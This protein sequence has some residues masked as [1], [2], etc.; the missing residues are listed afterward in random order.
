[1]T[2]KEKLFSAYESVKDKVICVT[3]YIRLSSGEIEVLSNCN[4]EN[5]MA[6]IDQVYDD[7]LAHSNDVRVHIED[8]SFECIDDLMD[9]GNALVN[10]K[11]GH[12]VARKGWSGKDMFLCL[13]DNID[14]DTNADLSC[15]KDLSGDLVYQSVVM[16]TVD[17]KFVVGWIPSQVDMLAEDWVVVE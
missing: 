1:M 3:L 14:F 16:K 7:D 5:K 4:V 17:N 9:F 15:V 6:Y 13:T 10:L 8:Y 12:K 11:A 2:E